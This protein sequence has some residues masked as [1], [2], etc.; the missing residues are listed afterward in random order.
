MDKFFFEFPYTP[1]DQERD[2]DILFLGAKSSSREHIHQSLLLKYPTKRI[3][4][5]YEYKH[6]NPT[7]ILQRS[8]YVLN[9]PYYENSR[10][11]THRI[12]KALACGCKILSTTS[13]PEYFPY[14]GESSTKTYPDL[15]PTA[16][17]HARYLKFMLEYL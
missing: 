12:N 13:T 1:G 14:L 9:I 5:D 15:L 10:L 11:E 7:A 8:K 2:I 16:E 6:M 3:V 4:F 17:Y